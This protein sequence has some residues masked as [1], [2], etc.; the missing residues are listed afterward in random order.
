MALNTRFAICMEDNCV[1]LESIFFIIC[2]YFNI[3]CFFF[4]IHAMKIFLAFF[5]R[6]N[7]F[8]YYIIPC[9]K[10]KLNL[11]LLQYSCF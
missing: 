7:E 10:S 11:L 5:E 2:I 6:H 4:N 1:H 8:F 9:F 3:F